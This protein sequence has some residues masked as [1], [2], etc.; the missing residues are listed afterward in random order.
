MP[1]ID[2]SLNYGRET[3]EKFLEHS[4]PFNTVV[5]IGAGGG[6]DLSIAKRVNPKS[7][8]SGIDCLNKNLE[9]LSKKGITPYKLNIETD[10]LPFADESIDVF[11]ANQILEHTKEL[12]W[13]FHEISRS[14]AVG[15]KVV[16]GVPNLAALHNR[17]LLLLGKQPSPVQVFSAHIRGFTKHGFIKFIEECFPGGYQ[18]RMFGGGNFYP[19][20]PLLAKPLASMFPNSAWSIFLLLEKKKAY[21]REFLNYPIDHGLETPF[22]TGTI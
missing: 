12:F 16:I 19:F 8:L 10:I 13:I 3:I 4:M 6:A 15:G 17:L 22:Y 20:P 5:D 18:V 9:E 14:L 21:T 2:K 7:Q 11:I 1:I